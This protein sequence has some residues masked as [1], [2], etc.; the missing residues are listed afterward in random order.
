MSKR[1]EVSSWNQKLVAYDGS[2]KVFEFD[3]VLGDKITP[4]RTGSFRITQKDP[5][6][7]SSQSHHPMPYSMFFDQGRAIHGGIHVE[8]RHL[9]M[10]AGLGRLDSVIPESMKIGSHG[11]VNLYRDDAR[12]LYDWAS[13]GTPVNVR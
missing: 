12:R 3:C 5:H 11:C 9:A 4:T 10:R 2:T 7:V 6:H 1:I 13:I 8:V